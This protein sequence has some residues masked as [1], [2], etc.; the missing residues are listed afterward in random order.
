VIVGAGITGLATG[1]MLATLGRDV[2]I[3]EAGEIAG[4][5][6]GSNTGKVSLLQGSTLS[7]LRR[8]HSASLV[9]AYADANRAGAEWL[10]GFAEDA[11]VST[12][13]R[14]AYSYT[15][16]DSGLDIDALRQVAEGI[17]SLRS[18]DRGLLLITHYQRLL[19]L[20]TPDVVHVLVDGRIVETG[21]PELAKALERS[22]YESYNA[23]ARGAHVS[24]RP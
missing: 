4:P 10:A 22:G 17:E 18:P 9:R 6:T 2:A 14:T 19:D 23:G 11:G 1:V 8:H 15:P 7:T 21:G 3:V 24:A 5:P 13:T 16:S 12:T 20:V